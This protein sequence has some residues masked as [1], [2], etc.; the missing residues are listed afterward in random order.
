MKVLI[1]D[2]LSLTKQDYQQLE[3]A[4]YQI[5]VYEQLI[6]QTADVVVG[7]FDQDTNIIFQIKGLSYLQL[8]S[9]GYDQL[10]L[11]KM[12]EHSIQLANAR[13]VYSIPIAEYV[14]GKILAF[15]KKDSLFV[16]QQKEK[17]WNRIRELLEL[18]NKTVGL[19]GTGSIAQETAK[20]LKGFDCKI[21]GLNTNGRDVE[22][23]DQCYSFEN[24]DALLSQSDI[25]ICTLPLNEQTHHIMNKEKFLKMKQD[26]MFINIGRGAEVNEQDL[27]EILDTHLSQVVLDVFEEE[28]L[29]KSSPLWSHPKVVITP[30]ISN[31]SDL[32]NERRKQLVIDNLLRFIRNEKIK[33]KIV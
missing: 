5:E 3:A 15:Y 22:Y 29:P 28:P 33:N 14:V 26:A 27:V 25:V 9:A 11:D 23:F 12:K 21:I 31:A 32:I 30:H 1:T 8:L 18:T 19:L 7:N 2:K 13:G 20:R 4:G 17:N 6:N 10:D 24:I 16:E